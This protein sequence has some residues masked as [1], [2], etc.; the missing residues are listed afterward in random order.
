MSTTIVILILVGLVVLA[1]LA[2]NLVSKSFRMPEHGWRAAIVVFAVG[3]A[4]LIVST[5]PFKQ[6]IDLVGGVILRYEVDEQKTSEAQVAGADDDSGQVD[7][8]MSALVEAIGKR[9]NPGGVQEIVVRPY[10][11][12]QV[13]IVIPNV[14]SQEVKLIKQKIITGGFLKFLIVA[15]QRNHN[16][17]WSLADEPSQQGNTIIVDGNNN[18]VGQW[19]DVDYTDLDDGTRSYNVD[20]S[21][22][23]TREV[24]GVRQVLMYIDS[25]FPL[26]GNHLSSVREGYQD[27][28]PCVFFNMT[29][30]GARLMGGI[31]ASNKPDA[32]SGFKSRLG[33]V[34]DGVLI[35]APG[36]NST[37][38]DSGIIEGN[39]SSD[40]VRVL[41]DVLRAGQLPAV[42]RDTPISESDVSALLG[43][44]TI[45]RGKTAIGISLVAVLVFMLIY[46]RF[47]GIVSSF[48]LLLNLLLIFAMM[49]FV[50]AAFSLAG[51]AG[52]VLTVGMSVDA[53]VLIFERIREELRHGAGL[54]MAIRNG[55]SRATPT[56]VDAN[57]TNL[58][59]ALVLYGMGGEQLQGYAV[60]LILGIL[61]CLFT[62]IFVSRMVFEIAE[63]QRWIKKLS[64]MQ[65]LAAPKWNLFGYRGIAAVASIAV[66]SMGLLC[67]ASRGEKLF[68]IDFLGGN[69][70]T[71]KLTES[72]PIE[73][74][75]KLTGG[76]ADDVLVTAIQ[77][78]E[79]RD[80][81]YQVDTS[82]ISTA[83]NN[84]ELNVDDVKASLATSLGKLLVTHSV[85]FTE[86]TAYVAANTSD[87]SA[88]TVDPPVDSGP[89]I[90]EPNIVVPDDPAKSDADNS[91]QAEESDVEA[92]ESEPGESDSSFIGRDSDQAIALTNRLG[93][94]LS[95]TDVSSTSTATQYSSTITF[96]ENINAETLREAINNAATKLNLAVPNF[97]LKNDDWDGKSSNSF[98]E[99][100]LVMTASQEDTANILGQL[101]TTLEESP[102]WLSANTVGSKVAGDTKE[103][104]IAAIVMSLLGIVAYIWIRFQRVVFGLAAVVA[105]IHDVLVTIG[106]I[107]FSYY[108][109]Q[110]VSGVAAPL[111][112]NEFKISLPV[113]AAIL[114]IIG[115]SLN[116]TIVV[117]DRI[118]EV[119]GKSPEITTEIINSSINQTLSRTILTS[120]TTLIAVTIL[121][122]LGGPG[123]HPFSFAL[124]VGVVVGTYSSIFVASP[125]L[126][127]MS[128]SRT[129]K[130]EAK[131]EKVTV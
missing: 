30:R 66:I 114:T 36:I 52:L 71:L 7:F 72:T 62:S 21:T 23:K 38:T 113:V 39:F 109:V 73:E 61:M 70:V 40:E 50:G 44:D 1:F 91:D 83:T 41:V 25:N 11:E 103:S 76:V 10:G 20:T 89:S 79:E 33:I 35:S 29:P 22:A 68:D 130:A 84:N 90:S 13:E 46:Y 123:I 67:A 56:I 96:D 6:G 111:M 32:S 28:N 16:H 101:K 82:R 17:V 3:V 57:V 43:A 31:T 65:L 98:A 100:Q 55:F 74:V 4:I 80:Q 54:R 5:T 42:L 58:I 15:N 69:S 2:S 87:S 105:L 48:A 47:A 127:W 106:A 75:R 122:F 49:I 118:R 8:K 94:L 45:R 99:W 95:Q 51:F 108:V 125:A 77:S 124:M 37:I 9:I 85:S 86:P 129:E 34:L 24:G 93:M 110:Y 26:E 14:G 115:Y 12:K 19:V 104:A 81:I 119:K 60:P 92:D 59:T 112:I 131:P 120:L 88:A 102:V 63:R 126:L 78:E 64:M 128:K 107:G 18:K 121:Y 97:E 116:D 117:F 53:N 27:L